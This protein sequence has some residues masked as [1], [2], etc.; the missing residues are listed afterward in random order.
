M[1][2]TLNAGGQISIPQQIR[3]ADHLAVGDSFEVER[4][5]SGHYVL[6]REGREPYSF[7]V[8]V[9]DD[10]LPIIRGANGVITSA[11][12]KELENQTR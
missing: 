3:D 1:K 5:A 8:L 10:G 9:G 6:T 11:L 2:A 7:T 4:L 12:V